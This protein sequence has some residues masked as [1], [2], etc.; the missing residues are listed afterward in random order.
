MTAVCTAIESGCEFVSGTDTSA[1]LRKGE[2]PVL[3]ADDSPI[4]TECGQQAGVS[5]HGEWQSRSCECGAEVCFRCAPMV[6]A[7]SIPAPATTGIPTGIAQLA[8]A[9][10][11]PDTR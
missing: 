3:P 9:I 8:T 2:A 7:N 11:L 1:T 4:C 10:P 6:S 5:A